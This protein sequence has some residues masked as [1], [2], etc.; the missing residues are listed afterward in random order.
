MSEIV[1][2][3]NDFLFCLFSPK[4]NRAVGNL[5]VAKRDSPSTPLQDQIAPRHDGYFSFAQLFPLDVWTPRSFIF[6]DAMHFFFFFLIMAEMNIMRSLFSF[7]ELVEPYVYFF[8]H[9]EGDTLR[10]KRQ[11]RSN[12][13]S[14]A[15]RANR[16]AHLSSVNLQVETFSLTYSH[17]PTFFYDVAGRWCHSNPAILNADWIPAPFVQPCDT[18]L[19]CLLHRFVS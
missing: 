7:Q 19:G 16:L 12:V 13:E 6:P 8:F 14:A 1:F 9:S 17:F 18:F 11:R 10:S 4:R 15:C 3:Q 5:V 2:Q